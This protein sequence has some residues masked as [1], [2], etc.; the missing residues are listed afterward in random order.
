MFKFMQVNDYEELSQ[1][2]VVMGKLG[3]KKGK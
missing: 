2:K 3:E 1:N